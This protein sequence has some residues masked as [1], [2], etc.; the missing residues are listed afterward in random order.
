[1]TGYPPQAPEA[2]SIRLKPRFLVRNDVCAGDLVLLPD[3][4]A[5]ERVGVR[6]VPLIRPAPD[7][8]VRARL[9]GAPRLELLVEVQPTARFDTTYACRV[10]KTHF[11]RSRRN[12]VRVKPR[13]TESARLGRNASPQPKTHGPTFFDA[14]RGVEDT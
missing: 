9:V 14:T 2:A 8:S 4:E 12:I 6:V 7:V 1:M 5:A 10:Y 13:K 3:R 11:F